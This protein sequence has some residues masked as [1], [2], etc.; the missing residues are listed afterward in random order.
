[1]VVLS[2]PGRVSNHPRRRRRSTP[3]PSSGT[4]QTTTGPQ[5]ASRACSAQYLPGRVSG[6]LPPGAIPPALTGTYALI[7]LRVRD[8][9]V[10]RIL[11][12]NQLPQ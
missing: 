1:M 12:T 2:R 9:G 6:R 11:I 4:P 5:P 8:P 7:I 3:A 10:Y